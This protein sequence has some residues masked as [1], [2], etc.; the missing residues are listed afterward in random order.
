FRSEQGKEGRSGLV[1]GEVE[2][3]VHQEVREDVLA[4]MDEIH[5]QE[6]EVIEEIDGA[7]GI[8][9][10]DAVEENRPPVLE[11]DVAQMQIAMRAAHAPLPSPRVQQRAVGMGE[12]PEGGIERL[13]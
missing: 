8:A 9:E 7:D 6:G 10:L 3:A 2:I 12:V 11:E 13:D 5:Q 1:P 4:T